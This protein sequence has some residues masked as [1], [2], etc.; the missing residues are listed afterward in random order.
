MAQADKEVYDII[1]GKWQDS[2]GSKSNYSISDS[3]VPSC[4]NDIPIETSVSPSGVISLAQALTIATVHNRDYQA[5]KERLYLT[6]LDLTLVRHQ[7]ARR[8]FGTVDAGYVRD[9]DD[10]QIGADARTGFSQLLADGAQVSASLAIDW[11]R[12]LAGDSGTSLG[13]VLSASITQPLLRGRGRKVAQE[14]LT[15]AERNALYQI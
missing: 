8:W 7:F 13:S 10:E 14:N 6:V 11:V 12:F 5:E 4:P 1:T 15:Q 9:G 3:N 2:H